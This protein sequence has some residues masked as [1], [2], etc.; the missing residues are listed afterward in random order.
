MRIGFIISYAV[1]VSLI[2]TAELF[3]QG[4]EE[5]GTKMFIVALFFFSLRVSLDLTIVY[6]GVFGDRY[7]V[8]DS[9]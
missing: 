8:S 7:E 6:L 1:A 9:A 3:R 5:V 2:A 4:A